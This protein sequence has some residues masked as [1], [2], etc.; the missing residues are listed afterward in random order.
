MH[1]L[2][3][4]I[5]YA[6]IRLSQVLVQSVTWEDMEAE[7]RQGRHKY[8]YTCNDIMSLEAA[9]IDIMISMP[10]LSRSHAR[11]ERVYVQS[12][13]SRTAAVVTNLRVRFSHCT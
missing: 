9:P 6:S 2:I 12:N 7:S 4:C 5:I 11:E 13:E 3:E 8:M 10:H 1:I